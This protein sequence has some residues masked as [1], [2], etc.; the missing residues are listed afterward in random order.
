[1][2]GGGGEAE[3]YLVVDDKDGIEIPGDVEGGALCIG[4]A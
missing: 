2:L 1:L 4:S 3:A